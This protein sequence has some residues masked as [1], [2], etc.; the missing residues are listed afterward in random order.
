MTGVL[1]AVN[2]AVWGLW[3]TLGR[4]PEGLELLS[5]N[6]LVSPAAIT[7]G[8]VWTLLLAELS[9]IDTAHLTFN[10]IALWTF[11]R[12][13]ERTIGSRR[14]L[15]LYVVGGIVASACYLVYAFVVG[16]DTP[17]LGASGAVS[18]IADSVKATFKDGVLEVAMKVPPQEATR[19]RR[20]E[21]G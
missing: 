20:I 17:A 14:L 18:A 10:M 3:Q 16:S 1:V 6:F 5:A 9:H 4:S 15:S 7:E 13:V 2:V 11:G 19:G 12:A 8:R 21:I